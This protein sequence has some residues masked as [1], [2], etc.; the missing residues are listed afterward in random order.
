MG[1][2][3]D[4]D[5][6]ARYPLLNPDQAARLNAK[7]GEIVAIRHAGRLTDAQVSELAVALERQT[8]DAEALH[9]FPLTNADEPVLI[10]PVIKTGH[11]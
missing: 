3:D 6:R 5:A 10:R 8:S 9:R 7:L 1:A 11:L 2:L 4:T